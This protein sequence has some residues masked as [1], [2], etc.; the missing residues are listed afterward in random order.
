MSE[1]DRLL[2]D[3]RTAAENGPLSHALLERAFQLATTP[4]MEHAVADAAWPKRSP[5]ETA[6]KLAPFLWDEA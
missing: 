2:V 6:R 1:F 3:V 4:A 5:G